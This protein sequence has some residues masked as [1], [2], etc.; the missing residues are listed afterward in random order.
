MSNKALVW[1]SIIWLFGAVVAFGHSAANEYPKRQEIYLQCKKNPNAWCDDP[2]EG[3]VAVALMAGVVWPLYF[4]W[5]AF[6][7]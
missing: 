7:K 6:E 3:V 2:R 5:T 4:S 1:F